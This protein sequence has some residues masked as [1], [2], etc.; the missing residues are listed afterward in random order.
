MLSREEHEPEKSADFPFFGPIPNATENRGAHGNRERVETC[1]CG[2][3]RRINYN[4]H[5]EEIG[6]WAPRWCDG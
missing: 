6:P 2:S 1:R 3:I 5:H 4:G